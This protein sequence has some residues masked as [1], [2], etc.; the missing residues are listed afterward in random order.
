LPM[1]NT[2]KPSSDTLGSAV[3]DVILLTVLNTEFAVYTFPEASIAM[4]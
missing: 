1:P 4:L 2:L 3:A